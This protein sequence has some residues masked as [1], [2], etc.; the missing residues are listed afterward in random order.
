MFLELYI[1]VC[2]LNVVLVQ[3]S[4]LDHGPGPV[5]DIVITICMPQP[6]LA[7]RAHVEMDVLD[8]LSKKRTCMGALARW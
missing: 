4:R 8:E 7:V 3:Q 2:L 1:Y 5:R 6:A